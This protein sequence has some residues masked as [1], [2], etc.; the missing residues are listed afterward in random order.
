[1]AGKGAPLGNKYATKSKPFLDALR[2]LIA[3]DD[4]DPKIKVNRLR[5]AAGQLLSQA[6]AGEEWAIKELANR[7]DGRAV[8]AVALTDPSGEQNMLDESML[9]E[10][11]PARLSQLKT[12]LGEAGAL[13]GT[14]TDTPEQPEEPD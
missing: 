10:M 5:K 14:A 11:D 6:A 4:M 3:A 2:K 8:Q 1:M 7:L 9:R 13:I 12:L